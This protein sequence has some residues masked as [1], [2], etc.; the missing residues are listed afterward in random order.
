MLGI[1][2]ALCLDKGKRFT[3]TGY[4]VPGCVEDWTWILWGNP[5]VVVAAVLARSFLDHFSQPLRDQ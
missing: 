5:S 1:F 4:V 2:G 3:L